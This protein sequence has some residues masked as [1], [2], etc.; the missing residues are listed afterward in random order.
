[1]EDNYKI[2]AAF[3]ATMVELIQYVDSNDIKKDDIVT[4]LPK[5]SG[6]YIIYY[7]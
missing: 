1:M 4:I 5:E 3:V 6:Y 7:K 2:Q